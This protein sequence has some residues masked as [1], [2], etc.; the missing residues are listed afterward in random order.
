MDFVGGSEPRDAARGSQFGCG[1]EMVTAVEEERLPTSER[2][3]ILA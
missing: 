3:T 2:I 1:L